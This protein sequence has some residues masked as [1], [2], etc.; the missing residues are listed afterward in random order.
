MDTLL[1]SATETIKNNSSSI[2]LLEQKISGE[3][4]LNSQIATLSKSLLTFKNGV[5]DLSQLIRASGN[6]D[7]TLVDEVNSL[8]QRF[9]WQEL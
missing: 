9:K 1:T 7:S 3:N 5:G 4:G 6:P 2:L 8:N